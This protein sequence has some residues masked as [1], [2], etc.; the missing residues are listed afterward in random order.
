MQNKCWVCGREVNSHDEPL[1]IGPFGMTCMTCIDTDAEA[2]AIKNRVGIKGEKHVVVA[3][4][5]T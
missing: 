1:K 4:G 2:E 3:P 5:R